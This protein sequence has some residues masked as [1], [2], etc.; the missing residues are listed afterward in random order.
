[1]NGKIYADVLRAQRLEWFYDLKTKIYL[2][3]IQKLIP[4]AITLGAIIGYLLA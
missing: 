2:S 4:A 3:R 1:M